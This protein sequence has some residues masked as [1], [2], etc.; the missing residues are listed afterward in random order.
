MFGSHDFQQGLKLLV[1]PDG[2]AARMII[3]HD[4]NPATTEGISHVDAEL[5]DAREAVKGT[6][7]ADAKFY[8]G[9][10]AASGK[11]I[12][13][14]TKYEV[15]V[16]AMAALML[17]FVVM[18]VLT[19]ALIASLVIVGTVVLSLATGFGLCPCCSGRILSA[20]T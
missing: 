6:P 5:K 10:T 7:L 12:Q 3:T 11:D 16:E 8:L 20:W 19:R 15:M 1:S 9:G 17:I 14:S 4:G 18:L 13:E 2:R